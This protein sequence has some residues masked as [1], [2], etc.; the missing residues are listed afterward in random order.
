[1]VSIDLQKAI[2]IGLIVPFHRCQN[3]LPQ[4]CDLK[5]LKDT[6][7][8]SSKDGSSQRAKSFIKEI[9]QGTMSFTDEEF[10]RIKRFVER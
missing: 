7:S 6:T 2:I 8:M 3:S 4:V 5:E 9:E 10:A 1:M